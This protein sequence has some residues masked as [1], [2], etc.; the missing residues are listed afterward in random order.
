MT[1]LTM[2]GQDQR[3]VKIPSLFFIPKGVFRRSRPS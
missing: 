2:S 1:L 3:F